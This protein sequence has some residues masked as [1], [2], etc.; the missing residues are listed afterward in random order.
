MASPEAAGT[1]RERRDTSAVWRH[2]AGG[3]ISRAAK[4]S[5][6]YFIFIGDV[7]VKF[8]PNLD[9]CTR[10]KVRVRREIP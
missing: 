4:V 3:R 2:E 6:E 1:G 10:K 8:F 7:R 5:N 9:I